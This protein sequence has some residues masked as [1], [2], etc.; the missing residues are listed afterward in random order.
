MFGLGQQYSVYFFLSPKVFSFLCQRKK[1]GF[2]FT[3]FTHIYEE[4]YNRKGHGRA[5]WTD[6]S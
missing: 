6:L 5:H 3:L 1:A 2:V 4:L